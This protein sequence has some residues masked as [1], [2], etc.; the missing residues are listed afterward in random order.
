MYDVV[1]FD[2]PQIVILTAGTNSGGFLAVIFQQ[3]FRTVPF[4]SFKM[5]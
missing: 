3:T 4:A 5:Y 2:Y 1:L